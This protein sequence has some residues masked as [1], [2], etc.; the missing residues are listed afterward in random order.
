MKT[1]KKAAISS[2]KFVCVLLVTIFTITACDN[3]SGVTPG[4]GDKE[5]PTESPT[6]VPTEVPTESPTVPSITFAAALLKADPHPAS[7]MEEQP[8]VLASYNDGES[9]FY[10]V[11]VGYISDMY[12][13]TIAGIRYTGVPVD[14]TKTIASTETVTNSL[15]TTVSESVAISN[16][17][18][19]KVS[20]GKEAGASLG[21]ANFAVKTNLEASW[22]GTLS[23]TTTKST[24]NTATTATQYA[25]SQTIKYQ[26]GA[27]DKAWPLGRYRYALYGVCDVYFILKTSP[28]NQTL[29]GWETFVCARP[30][31][32]EVCTEYAADGDFINEQPIRTIDFKKDFYK[33]LPLPLVT[34]DPVA[35]DPKPPLKTSHSETRDWS[36]NEITHTVQSETLSPDLPIPMLI[37]AGYKYLK[38][39]LN[40]DFKADSIWAG[41]LRLQ[42]ADCNKAGELGRE[43]F[44]HR[45][46]WFR[47]WFET[48]VSIDATNSDTGQFSLLWSRVEESDLFHCEYSVGNRVITITALK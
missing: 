16:T 39:E 44:A 9:N 3:G 6:E 17:L 43:D 18:G 42:V 25:E 41:N 47:S 26:I 48:T 5:V 22:S 28:D 21:V 23:N 45:S 32:Y 31:D 10:L 24:S 8:K 12:I 34:E 7:S 35:E 36:F 1:L 37:Q 20:I 14:F 30:N 33:N 29:R 2:L 15:T 46:N 11:D 13:S 38:I 27:N 40:F 4:L 19:V